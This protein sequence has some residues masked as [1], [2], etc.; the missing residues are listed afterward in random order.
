ETRHAVEDAASRLSAAGASVREIVLAEEFSRLYQASRET[1]NN[2]E[3]ARSMASDWAAHGDRIS[4]VLGDRVKLG[5]ATPQTEYVAAL[6]LAERCRALVEPHFE[7]LD[8]IIAPCTKGEAILGLG[9]TGDP[10]FQ[11]FW[12]ALYVPTVSLPTHSGPKGLP[13]GIQLV[14]AR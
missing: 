6:R 8:A 10:A 13:V 2:Y 9:H 5:M 14:A 12:T 1:I 3:R 4:K 11:Q 7:G